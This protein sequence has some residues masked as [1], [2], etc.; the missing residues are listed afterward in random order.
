MVKQGSQ[1]DRLLAAVA[2]YL[3]IGTVAISVQDQIVY[4]QHLINIVFPPHTDAEIQGG[5]IRQSLQ[6]LIGIQSGLGLALRFEIFR[7]A[8]INLMGSA[9]HRNIRMDQ[10][11]GQMRNPQYG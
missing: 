11:I 6:F 2:Q 3:N 5:F 8:E 10:L 1:T 7:G 9:I 4:D